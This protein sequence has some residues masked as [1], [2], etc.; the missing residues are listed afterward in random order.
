MNAK[1]E[2]EIYSLQKIKL[3][4]TIVQELLVGVNAQI[5]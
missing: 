1:N 5:D 3:D 2:I 4:S